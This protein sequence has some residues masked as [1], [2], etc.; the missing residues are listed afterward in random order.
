MIIW[1]FI[2]IGLGMLWFASLPMWHNAGWGNG[3]AALLGVLLLVLLLGAPLGNR[4]ET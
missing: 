3:P 2:K 4:P 1:D